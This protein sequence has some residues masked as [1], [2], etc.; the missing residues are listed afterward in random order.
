[1]VYAVLTEGG[2]E[3][4][5]EASKSHL[6]QID[7]LFAERFEDGELTTLEDFLVRLGDAATGVDCAPP[8]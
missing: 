4:L 3:K 8:E 6:G 5:G 7:E 2:R 1:V